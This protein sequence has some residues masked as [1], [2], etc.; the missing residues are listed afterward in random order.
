MWRSVYQRGGKKLNGEKAGLVA[1]S[2]NEKIPTGMDSPH[3]LYCRT[4]F[5]VHKVCQAISL[6]LL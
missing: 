4:I 5:C 2:D 6:G 3:L 1:E